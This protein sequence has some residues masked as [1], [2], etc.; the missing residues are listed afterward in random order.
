MG[1]SPMNVR[2]R[3]VS[4]AQVLL[5][6]CKHFPYE[7]TTRASPPIT[8]ERVVCFFG[9]NCGLKFRRNI[10]CNSH[11]RHNR[12]PL[13]INPREMLN[14]ISVWLTCRLIII[15]INEQ[16]NVIYCMIIAEILSLFKI[17]MTTSVSSRLALSFLFKTEMP[18]KKT[19]DRN[20][21]QF[22]LMQLRKIQIFLVMIRTHKHSHIHRNTHTQNRGPTRLHCAATMTIA[23]TWRWVVRRNKSKSEPPSKTGYAAVW[24][25]TDITGFS[26]KP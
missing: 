1:L 19:N 14:K 22:P 23:M 8:D 21:V 5:F 3:D 20:T 10:K 17:I 16:L 13:S 4:G 7:S 2:G 18:R 11:N 24:S 26:R 9:P 12:W 25:Q 15:Q 6:K